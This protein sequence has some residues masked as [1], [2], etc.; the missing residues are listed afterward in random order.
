MFLVVLP[1]K[2]LH[3]I[4]CARLIL[5][6]MIDQCKVLYLDVTVLIYNSNSQSSFT[7]SSF[8]FKEVEEM[9]LNYLFCLERERFEM[10]AYKISY[11]EGN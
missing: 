11:L 9:I 7:N 3:K 4:K 8:G 2:K 10:N 6:E 5:L 1:Y